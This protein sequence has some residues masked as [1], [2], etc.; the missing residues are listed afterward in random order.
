MLFSF[1]WKSKT[2]KIKRSTI[3]SSIAE[4]G[5]NI[6]DVYAVHD[7]AKCSWIRRF[8]D[9]NSGKWKILFKELIEIDVNN[10]NKN[11]GSN[12][13]NLGK[14]SF[15][16]QILTA[17]YK[18]TTLNPLT[19][20]DIRDQFLLHNHHIKINNNIISESFFRSPALRNITIG[21]ILSNDGLILP[22]EVLNQSINSNIHLLKYNALISAI[23]KKWKETTR[24]NIINLNNIVHPVL[25]SE[26][27]PQIKIRGKN[28]FISKVTSKQIY[29]KFIED[30]TE[31]PTAI[32]TWVNIYPFLETINWNHIF[33]LSF[34][35]TKE[36]YLQSFQ[37]KILNRI[38]N[39]RE[40]LSTWNI[41]DT[42]KCYSC[43]KVDTLEHH[44]FSCPASRKFW[45]QLENWIY[46]N[47]ETYFSFTECEIIFGIPLDKNNIEIKI[48]NY[49]I[50]LGKWYINKCRSSNTNVYFIELLHLTK[51]KLDCANYIN[52]INE[53]EMPEWQD[54]LYCML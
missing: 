45:L 40:K 21:D 26:N 42:N 23:P 49:L 10:L 19:V 46:N 31:A 50:L 43:N 13:L 22:I 35:T 20:N 24:R 48:I 37:Y 16:K 39:M 9:S 41:I 15:H 30:R 2:S 6:V 18:A 27:T 11:L 53:A 12:L 28:K 8:F 3:I 4:G 32:N 17:W 36:P 54:R 5:L 34:E 38:L 29:G 1:L 33:T 25:L 14:T 51:N 44:L 7:A 52:C 47:L